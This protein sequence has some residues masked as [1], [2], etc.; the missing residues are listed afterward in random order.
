MLSDLGRGFKHFL[1]SPIFGMTYLNYYT[2]EAT[3]QS[4]IDDGGTFVWF[5]L[6]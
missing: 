5:P 3:N 6:S 2:V 1:F 4:H